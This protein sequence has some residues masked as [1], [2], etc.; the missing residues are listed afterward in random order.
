MPEKGSVDNLISVWPAEE[1]KITI[2]IPEPFKS[3]PP[4]GL[5][6]WNAPG[7]TVPEQSTEFTFRW[8]DTGAK[9][10]TITI[11]GSKFKVVVDL[12]NVGNTSQGDA[13]LALDPITSASVVLYGVEAMNYSNDKANFPTDTP[14]KDSIRHS[15]WTALCAS[16]ILVDRH[17][18]LNVT[19]AHEHNNKW[20]IGT[21]GGPGKG[22]QHA[23]NSTMDL[24]NNLI[25][26]ATGH[27]TGIGTPD[28]PAILQ[29]LNQQYQQGLMWI[30]DGNEEEFKSKGI[31]SKS[32]RQ[33]IYP[34]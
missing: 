5:I 17:G 23:F 18:V 19:T 32:N 7:H 34:L 31:L 20:N 33:K 2:D 25:G 27:F 14:K 28:R 4:A 22:P 13:L 21:F 6:S 8:L 1:L 24:R 3:N 26:I 12:P 30:Y 16:D 10:I 15:Y 11:G 9:T 29:D